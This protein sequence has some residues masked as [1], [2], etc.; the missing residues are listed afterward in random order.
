VISL[1]TNFLGPLNCYPASNHQ[2][3]WFHRATWGITPLHGW[4]ADDLSLLFS[5][6]RSWPHRQRNVGSIRF[7]G[8]SVLRFISYTSWTFRHISSG[9]GRRCGNML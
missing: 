9:N 2:I 7:Y 3:Q 5:P 1:H 4:L 6:W 8:L